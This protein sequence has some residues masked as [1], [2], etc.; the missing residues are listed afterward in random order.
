MRSEKLVAKAEDSSGTQRNGGTSAV[1]S[2][3]QATASEDREDFVY[4][5][6]SLVFGVCNSV[7]LL[8]LFGVM[9]AS[10]R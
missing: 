4:A 3:Y 2:R 10:V 9:S 8:W 5:V 6:V 1:G 7:R